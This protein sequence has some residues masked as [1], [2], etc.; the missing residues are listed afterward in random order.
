MHLRWICL[1]ELYFRGDWV[2]VF[3]PFLRLQYAGQVTVDAGAVNVLTC[4]NSVGQ[5]VFIWRGGHF[6]IWIT[7][8]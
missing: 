4:S 1:G 5:S 2:D 6:A 7:K 3:G 8:R